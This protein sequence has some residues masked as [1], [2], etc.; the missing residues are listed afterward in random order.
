MSEIVDLVNKFDKFQ[1]KHAKGDIA[2][3]CRYYL[4]KQADKHKDVQLV[5]PQP[6]TPQGQLVKLM[7]RLLSVFAI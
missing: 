3:F 2:D 1:K 7:G 6:P 4:A 5:G